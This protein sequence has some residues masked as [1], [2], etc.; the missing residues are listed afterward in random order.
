MNS[1]VTYSLPLVMEI[2]SWAWSN[3]PL[4]FVEA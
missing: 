3:R 2:L 1:T 4:T